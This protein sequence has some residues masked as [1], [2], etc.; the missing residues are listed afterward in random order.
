[1][2]EPGNKYNI[3][4]MKVSLEAVFRRNDSSKQKSF[5]L[6]AKEL[7]DECSASISVEIICFAYLQQVSYEKL[8]PGI[9]LQEYVQPNAWQAA[10]MMALW[11]IIAV[12]CSSSLNFSSPHYVTYFCS[13]KPSKIYGESDFKSSVLRK[14]LGKYTFLW[15]K[16]RNFYF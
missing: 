15:F 10:T 3:L 13:P 5:H 2:P 1:M 4:H 8:N 9:F 14:K 11:K 7:H 12:F 16:K 6:S